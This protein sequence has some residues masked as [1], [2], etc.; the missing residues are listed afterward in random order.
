MDREQMKALDSKR[1]KADEFAALDSILR[2]RG[3]SFDETLVQAAIDREFSAQ[4]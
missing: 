3:S 1:L 2:G 4:T